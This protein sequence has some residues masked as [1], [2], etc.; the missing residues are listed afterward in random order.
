MQ[1]TLGITIFSTFLFMNQLSFAKDA[2]LS[3]AEDASN[4]AVQFIETLDA[5]QKSRALFQIEAEEK[6]QWKYVPDSTWLGKKLL[7]IPAR[8]GLKI[9]LLNPGQKALLANLLKSTMSQKGFDVIQAAIFAENNDTWGFRGTRNLAL[10]KYTP[11][12][13][14]VSVFG[15][16]QSKQ[17]A[18]KFEGHHVSISFSINEGQIVATPIFIGTN[19][20]AIMMPDGSVIRPLEAVNKGIYDLVN[21]FSIK[22]EQI[23]RSGIATLP[24]YNLYAPKYNQNILDFPEPATGLSLK[25][26]DDL[27]TEMVGKIIRNYL[28]HLEETV[29]DEKLRQLEISKDQIEI[30]WM[31]PRDMSSPYY[32]RLQG[33]AFILEFMIS[34]DEH[35]HF[36]SVWLDR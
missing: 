4:K 8:T 24:E 5:D 11:D 35:G 3:R 25:N 14:Y 13:Y 18:W 29:R 6:S 28:D 2:S 1:K 20:E 19:P 12:N 30:V 16:P 7:K 31:G 17:W 10:F 27:Q 36:H 32:F 9:S 34:D 22:Q 23:A 33:P 21:S 26:T 15:N